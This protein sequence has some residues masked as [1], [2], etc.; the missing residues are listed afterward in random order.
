VKPDEQLQDAKLQEVA[1]RL[2][3]QAADRLDV[4][5][6]ARAVLARLRDEP[7][8]MGGG[9]SWVWR[10]PAWLRVAAAVVVLVTG[11]LVT[12]AVLVERG[13]TDA[14][15]YVAEDLSDLSTTQL[16][17]L[18]STLDQTLDP[19]APA[20]PEPSLDQLTEDELRAMLRSLEG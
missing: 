4:E 17:Q 19:S 15:H 6:T 11:G 7:R 20:A 10:Q 18:L 1:R 13:P 16:Q 8:A 2:G 12:R 3:A 14:G 9:G 5:R